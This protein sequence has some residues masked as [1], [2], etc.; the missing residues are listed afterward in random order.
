MVYTNNI[1][2]KPA[3][4]IHTIHY[5]ENEDQTMDTVIVENSAY[6]GLG[7]PYR[8]RG[9]KGDKGLQALETAI[10]KALNAASDL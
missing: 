1:F 5:T 2:H 4:F 3:N 7:T 10:N 6:T 9:L 8:K